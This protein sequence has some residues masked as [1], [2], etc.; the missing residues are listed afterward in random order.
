M[1]KVGV[2]SRWKR[3]RWKCGDEDVME[4]DVVRGGECENGG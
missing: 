2:S 4:E 1:S 3:G